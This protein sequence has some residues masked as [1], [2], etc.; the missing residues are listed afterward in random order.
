MK[1]GTTF[2]LYCISYIFVLNFYFSWELGSVLLSH[3]WE[4]GG[5]IRG[6]QRRGFPSGLAPNF[7]FST[8][9]TKGT[10]GS[11]Q[12][13][14]RTGLILAALRASFW[15]LPNLVVPEELW[16]ES[17]LDL[18]FTC[19][20]HFWLQEV[21]VSPQIPVGSLSRQDGRSSFQAVGY[22]L[23]SVGEIYMIYINRL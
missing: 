13:T 20:I 11:L 21:F 19:G 9:S 22:S 16:L 15:T 1:T 17:E 6:F 5:G 3:N 10:R 12:F 2:D 8:S 18:L 4:E 7:R 14:G 23:G